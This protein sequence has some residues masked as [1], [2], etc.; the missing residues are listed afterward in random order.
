MQQFKRKWLKCFFLML[1]LVLTTFFLNKV[2]WQLVLRYFKSLSMSSRTKFHSKKL[3]VSIALA[4]RCTSLTFSSNESHHRG[5][6]DLHLFM[7]IYIF[8]KF[9]FHEY[10]VQCSSI[11]F[12]GR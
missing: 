11:N 2:G 5:A 1:N 6:L 12:T 4:D 9:K 10:V 8:K 3:A 7:Y